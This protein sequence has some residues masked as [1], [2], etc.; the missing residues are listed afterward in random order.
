MTWFFSSF[1]FRTNSAIYSNSLPRSHFPPRDAGAEVHHP[2]AA[3]AGA[4]MEG[5][6]ASTKEGKGGK[7]PL[8]VFL[9]DGKGYV[10]PPFRDIQQV[11]RF[12]HWLPSLL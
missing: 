7:P 6:A 12:A 8:I 11:R 5:G 9:P 10:L 4:A 1:L 3:E 2:A